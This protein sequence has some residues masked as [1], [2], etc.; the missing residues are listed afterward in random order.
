MTKLE[1]AEVWRGGVSVEAITQE[2]GAEVSIDRGGPTGER[3]DEDGVH[4][5]FSIPSKGGGH[6]R[7]V[8][9]VPSSD[10]E[11]LIDA[12]FRGNRR[13]AARAAT[14]SMLKRLKTP[15]GL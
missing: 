12:V 10:F 13:L 6:T 8:V 11:P 5:E 9:F 1:G 15:Q 4:L 7:I 14:Q 2:K 3:F